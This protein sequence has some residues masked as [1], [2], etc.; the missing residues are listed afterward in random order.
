MAYLTRYTANKYEVKGIAAIHTHGAKLKFGEAIGYALRHMRSEKL[1]KGA[2][3]VYYKSK[4]EYSE[5]LEKG[6]VE[7]IKEV[8]E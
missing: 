8:I 5:C 1:K 4:E 6:W 7:N 2:I 3:V